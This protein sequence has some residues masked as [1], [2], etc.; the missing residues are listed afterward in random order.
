MPGL[1]HIPTLQSDRGLTGSGSVTAQLFLA[2]IH[3]LSEWSSGCTPPL[4]VCHF[5]LIPLLRLQASRSL[6]AL[7]K[8]CLAGE[9]AIDL[10]LFQE[11]CGRP[12]GHWAWGCSHSGPQAGPRDL[13]VLKH[14]PYCLVFQCPLQFLVANLH[15]CWDT[16]VCSLCS[17]EDGLGVPPMCREK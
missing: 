5:V 10:T 13:I 14:S 9:G 12:G 6:L 8:P 2:V 17:S 16:I 4:C 1:S 3:S 7:L 11:S 15:I